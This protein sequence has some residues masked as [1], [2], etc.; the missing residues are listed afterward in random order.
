MVV[1]AWSSRERG[2]LSKWACH[3]H[4][5]LRCVAKK[6]IFQLHNRS[7]NCLS[8]AANNCSKYIL[9]S[10][11]VLYNSANVWIISLYIPFVD[12][13]THVDAFTS[14]CMISPAWGDLL[15]DCARLWDQ[16]FARYAANVLIIS[17]WSL[18]LLWWSGLAAAFVVCEHFVSKI[19]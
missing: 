18:S 7:G 10:A 5:C 19:Y 17:K 12:Q 14:I 6:N 13:Y 3:G 1:V 16:H 8:R 2:G 11:V 9:I 15:H 4:A